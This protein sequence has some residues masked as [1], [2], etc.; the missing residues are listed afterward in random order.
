M[1][2]NIIFYCLTLIA[3][4]IYSCK[5]KDAFTITGTIT[6]PGSL[7][8]IYLIQQDSAGIS[9]VDS[10]TLN[11][12]NKF[13]FKHNAPFANVYRL[14]VGGAMFD[15]IAKNGDEIGFSTNLTDNTHT[16]QITGSEESEKIKEY[17]KISNYYT[18]LNNKL[19][20]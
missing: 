4:A 14:R 3:F 13:Q 17:N 15:F 11:E 5:N 18:G 7:K 8:N 16:Y 9:V 20:E 12:N 1:K 10:A 2:K 6:N 19:D